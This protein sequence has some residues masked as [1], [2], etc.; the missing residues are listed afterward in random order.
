MYVVIDFVGI[1]WMY[2]VVH[3]DV[4]LLPIMEWNICFVVYVYV[5]MYSL[6]NYCRLLY[7]DKPR[8]CFVRMCRIYII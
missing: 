2:A 8:V 4:F 1:H 6:I 5:N 3:G 7:L